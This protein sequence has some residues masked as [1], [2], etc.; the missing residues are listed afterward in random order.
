MSVGDV[1]EDC[2]II[3]L[4]EIM[5]AYNK[6]KERKAGAFERCDY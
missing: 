3:Q 1:Q 4:E 2:S 5:R 6:F